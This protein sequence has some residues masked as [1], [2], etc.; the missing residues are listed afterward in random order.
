MWAGEVKWRVPDD[1]HKTDLAYVLEGQ[2]WCWEHFKPRELACTQTGELAITVD[3]MEALERIRRWVDHPLVVT[4]GY[5]SP[6]FNATLGGHPAHPMGIAVDLALRGKLAYQ[7]LAAAP[8]FEFTGIG[9]SQ[10]RARGR[11]L[12]LDVGARVA[13][14]RSVRPM[15]WSY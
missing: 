15:V 13:R 9:V 11:F 6:E 10:H 7:V 4:S 2:P 3:L 5:R 14:L 1:A 12:H 8:Q